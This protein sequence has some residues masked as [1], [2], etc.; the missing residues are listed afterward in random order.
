VYSAVINW[1]TEQKLWDE[2]KRIYNEIENEDRQ[3]D[4]L[5]FYKKN[6]EAM[7]KGAKVLWPEK[8]SYYDLMCEFVEKGKRAFMKEKQ[9]MPLPSDDAL[10]DN[11]WWYYEEVR[12][13]IAGFVIEKTGAFIPKEEL[14]AYGALDPATGEGSDKRG[15]GL[16]FACI[17][18]GYKQFVGARENRLFVHSDF[19][20]KAKPT[21]YIEAIFH[22]NDDMGYAKCAVETNL[23]RG[24]LLENIK[25]ARREFEKERKKSGVKQ[26]SIKVPFYE[27]ENREK[28]TK[29]IFTLEPKVNNGWILFNRSLSIDFMNMIEEFPK[30]D[31]DDAPD[32][33][34]MLWSLV[35]NRYKP[36]AVNL[37][38]M[39]SR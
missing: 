1:S 33:L 13:G 19:T 6:E 23:Y 8:E 30:A 20:R 21:S 26:W 17:A 22:A 15:K 37:D 28:K 29:R 18:S 25:R 11:I 14:E 4:A 34:E 31:H 36:S 38:I 32:A 5:A 35:N 39:G 10:F 2:W 12:N 27:I 3:K 24:L 7:L 9:N 16:D